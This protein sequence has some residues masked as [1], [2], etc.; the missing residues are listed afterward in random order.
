MASTSIVRR[1][2]RSARR[3]S[4]T[5]ACCETSR[6]C[7]LSLDAGARGLKPDGDRLVNDFVAFGFCVQVGNV[8]LGDHF[9][10]GGDR[11]VDFLAAARG[12]QAPPDL[13]QCPEDLGS[14]ESLTIAVFT[15]AHSCRYRKPTIGSALDRAGLN[16]S[17]RQLALHTLP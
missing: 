15:E 9:E 11:L 12:L 17:A 7:S 16:R 3:C 13:S 6:T 14:I 8:E 1:S 5:C 4:R 2:R 10:G